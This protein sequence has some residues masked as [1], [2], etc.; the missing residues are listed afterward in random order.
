MGT[1]ITD[2]MIHIDESLDDWELQDIEDEIRMKDGVV[3]IGANEKTSHLF[4]VLYNPDRVCSG[5]ILGCIK[6]K[7]FHA[8]LVGL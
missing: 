1:S 4:M 8:E 6:T 5:D 7:G 2:V 3:S